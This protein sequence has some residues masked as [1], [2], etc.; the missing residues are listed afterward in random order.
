MTSMA[1]K[2]KERQAA[3]VW[4][5]RALLMHDRISRALELHRPPKRGGRSGGPRCTECGDRFPCQTVLLLNP[6]SDT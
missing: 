5:R 2:S 3:E 1:V 6:P 4:H